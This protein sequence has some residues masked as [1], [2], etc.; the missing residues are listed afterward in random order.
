[1]AIVN[2][3]PHVKSIKT[4]A[5]FGLQVSIADGQKKVAYQVRRSLQRI[6]IVQGNGEDVMRSD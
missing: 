3:F 6:L 5:S 2:N 4:E 1:M